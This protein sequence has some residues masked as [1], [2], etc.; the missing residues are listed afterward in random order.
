MAVLWGCVGADVVVDEL[1]SLDE[2][3]EED[4]AEVSEEFDE[5]F[6]VNAVVVEL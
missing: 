3:D 2:D 5:E 6:G 1:E 4:E